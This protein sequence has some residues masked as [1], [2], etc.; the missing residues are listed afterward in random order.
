MRT[1]LFIAFALVGLVLAARPM[2]AHHSFAAQFDASKTFKYTGTV[3]KVEWQNPHTYFYV[4][5]VDEATK[6]KANWAMEMGSP[7]VLMRSGWKRTTLK[8]GDQV[9]VEGT[10][11]RDGSNTGNARTVI[12]TATGQRLFAGSSQGVTP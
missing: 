1:K 2:L 9:T 7:N 5:V 6:Q 3:T 4:D 10:K 8:I 11:A 12:L